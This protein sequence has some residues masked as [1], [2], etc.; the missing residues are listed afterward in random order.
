VHIP[1]ALLIA[2]IAITPVILILDG[3]VIYSLLLALA[4]GGIAF[5]TLN[6]QPGEATHLQKLILPAAILTAI[7]AIWM[8]FQV[9]PLPFRQ[10]THP[11][12]GS[13]ATALRRSIVGSI[14]IDTG[15]TVLS[16][17]KYI[18]AVGILL[19]AAMMGVDRRRAKW[20]LYTLTAATTLISL[21]FL[22]FNLFDIK[23]LNILGDPVKRAEALDAAAFG[24]ILST[25]VGARVHERYEM[26]PTQTRGVHFWAGLAC[27][28]AFVLCVATLVQGRSKMA[29][30]AAFY[31]VGAVLAIA[32]IRRFNLGPWGLAGFAA[33]ALVGAIGLVA[34]SSA[35]QGT[36]LTYALAPQNQSSTVT[37][38][39]IILDAPLPG[40]GAGTYPALVPI[41]ST[42]DDDPQA[43]IP[44]TAAAA[45]SIE[46][47]LPMLCYTFV[48]LAIGALLLLRGALRRGRDSFYPAAGTACL[49]AGSLLLLGNYGVLGA[50]SA[51]LAAAT[52]GLAIGQS[53]SRRA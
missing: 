10:L 9:A 3:T 52:V 39:R 19:L 43:T 24:L 22:C 28:V 6:V 16:F 29:D 18:S 8:L 33:V 23:Y 26:R 44:P 13:A 30:F 4:A 47:G 20:F 11:V 49:I 42:L 35:I 53:R 46:L 2:I 1:T 32:S 48:A 21:L 45:I 41:Y 50:A 31:G 7:P 34:T 37:T 12:W 25:S 14:S 15:A 38:R 27:A 5:A 36:D 51:S 17:S 40:T